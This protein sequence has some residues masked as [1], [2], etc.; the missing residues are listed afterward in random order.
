MSY[1]QKQAKVSVV[2]VLVV[3]A[4]IWAAGN[5][6]NLP[7]RREE[8]T[9]YKSTRDVVSSETDDLSSKTD[10]PAPSSETGMGVISTL[11]KMAGDSIYIILY[12][13]FRNR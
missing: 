9:I 7:Q 11:I 6:S 4:F 12:C 8:S 13:F 5:I 2:L 3:V 10:A 1:F